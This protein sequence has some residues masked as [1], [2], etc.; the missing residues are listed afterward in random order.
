M[1]YEEL[2]P[3]FTVLASQ[4]H[5]TDADEPT[6]KAY[7]AGLN[8]LEPE[9]VAEA[10]RRLGRLVNENGQSWFPKLGEWR[11]LAIQVE[12]E[13][14]DRQK[15]MLRKLPA[16]LCPACADTGWRYKNNRVHRCECAELRRL[17][18]LG[19]QPLPKQLAAI[20]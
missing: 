18:L 16:P 11:Q 8:D 15:Q 7:H 6:A 20:G 10:A 4:T 1:T 3:M 13:W 17:E 9:F 19:R 14:I 5:F 2:V 12:R